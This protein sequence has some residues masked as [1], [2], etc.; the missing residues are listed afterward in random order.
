MKHQRATT[1]KESSVKSKSGGVEEWRSGRNLCYF[2]L[3]PS[4]LSRFRATEREIRT[5][6]AIALNNESIIL[7]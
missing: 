2:P 3:S 7:L 4:P 6:S 1:I 5:E